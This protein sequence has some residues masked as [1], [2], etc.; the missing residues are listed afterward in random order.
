MREEAPQPWRDSWVMLPVVV[1][2]ILMAQGI[3]LAFL[4]S[5]T[6]YDGAEQLL[7]SQY[8]DWGYGRSQPPLYTWALI[9]MHR[10]FGVGILAEHVLK[11]GLMSA[12]LLAVWDIARRIG[13]SV[14]VAATALAACFLVVEI[15][16][17]FQRNYAHS[18]LLFALTGA[19]TI[20]YLRG[21]L[22]LCGAIAAAIV[23]A[24]YNGILVIGALVVADG[25]GPRLF[26]S[27]RGAAALAVA[28]LL[29]VPHGLWA[30]SNA[31]AVFE[32]TDRFRA[33]DS[34]PWA[35]IAAYGIA[36]TGVGVL[37]A[38]VA[39]LARLRAR[40]TVPDGPARVMWHWAW[41][42]WTVCLAAAVLA[43]LDQVNMR[44]LLPGVVPFLP[45]FAIM[46]NGAHHRLAGWVRWIGLA[47]LLLFTGGQWIESTR[48]NARTDYDYASLYAE[49]AP[50]GTDAVPV[51]LISNYAVFANLRL[52]GPI[53]VLHPSMPDLSR[54]DPDNAVIVADARR[55][56]EVARWA[57][58][59]GLCA[60][61]ESVTT[62][63]PRRT[64]A[65]TLPV[66]LLTV[67]RAA[68]P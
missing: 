46:V 48:I 1:I 58:D 63:L 22:L 36:A 12:G 39:A 65:D 47:L 29:C 68:C 45:V 13:A 64:G 62:E 28:L 42:Y 17:E 24:K 14:P 2:A 35:A 33:E 60:Q 27:L 19:L 38:I 8:L 21:S 59:L 34:R 52:Y 18:V 66:E 16:W 37:L 5:G 49:L 4:R 41:V 40:L 51:A 11:F 57:R 43:G 31:N 61:G 54:F 53:T 9:A 20:A 50:P 55:G 15:G 10:I 56:V 25:I 7:Y 30:L 3:V 26:W 23:L 32:I 6:S 67:S 44:W